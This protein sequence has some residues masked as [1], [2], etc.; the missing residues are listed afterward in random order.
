MLDI[1]ERS[2]IFILVYYV[3]SRNQNIYPILIQVDVPVHIDMAG[4]HHFVPVQQW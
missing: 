3:N 4:Q 2:V 1:Y